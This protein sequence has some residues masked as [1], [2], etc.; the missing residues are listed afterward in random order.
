[1]Y[2]TNM[3]T[4]LY[5]PL[6]PKRIGTFAE[7]L[8]SKKTE[9]FFKDICLTME[10]SDILDQFQQQALINTATDGGF[11]QRQGIIS[12]GWVVAVNEMVI[13]KGKGP[14]EAH[15]V[16]AEAYRGDAYGLAAAT[17]FIREMIDHLSIQPKRRWFFHIDNKAL[18]KQMESYGS[19][20]IMARWM[21]LPD[22]DITNH[23][24]DKTKNL[25]PPVQTHK[26][27]SKRP[28]NIKLN[29]QFSS[30]T[31]HHGGCTR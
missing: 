28:E 11:D 25:D 18:I 22:I 31:K 2:I 26:K 1:M 20:Q 7:L 3:P 17:T 13:A 15:P 10:E 27:P 12:Y 24:H 21:H 5:Q 6:Q 4:P 29:N 30:P 8:D 14:A 19:E 23:A 9:P 16:I